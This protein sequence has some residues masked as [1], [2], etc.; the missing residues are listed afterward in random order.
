[1]AEF[2]SADPRTVIIHTLSIQAVYQV[3]TGPYIAIHTTHT[4]HF[5]KRES[6]NAKATSELYDYIDHN[7][8]WPVSS[9]MSCRLTAVLCWLGCLH[10]AMTLSLLSP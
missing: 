1:M 9:Q 3:E 4:I 8:C 5:N 2:L 6:A 10:G 7:E